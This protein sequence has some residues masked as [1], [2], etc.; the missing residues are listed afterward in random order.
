MKTRRPP[1]EDPDLSWLFRWSAADIGFKSSAGMG[2]GGSVSVEDRLADSRLTALR[3][4]GMRIADGTQ[5]EGGRKVAEPAITRSRRLLAAW[6]KLDA[7]D[8]RILWLAYGPHPL[9]PQQHANAF[10][11]WPTLVLSTHVVGAGYETY[12][13]EARAAKGKLVTT[14]RAKR[15]AAAFEILEWAREVA[16]QCRP[17]RSA[18][19]ELETGLRE[20]AL[21]DVPG[22]H[23]PTVWPLRE[24][25]TLKN[26][27]QLLKA[28][29]TE[30]LHVL[31]AVHERWVDA[32]GRK[33]P[34]VRIPKGWFFCPEKA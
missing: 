1:I 17:T 13:S 7:E 20:D 27:A 3:G 2:G 18:Q 21:V 32:V 30:A 10:G 4:E 14:A 9:P 5:R 31:S 33:A 25:C 28:G 24:W 19:R 29:A 22:G 26:Q 15:R 6:A 34:P 11:S 23:V 16:K 12:L 8:Q